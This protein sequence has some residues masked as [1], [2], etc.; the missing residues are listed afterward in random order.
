[1]ILFPTAYLELGCVNLLL[2]H[3]NLGFH[4]TALQ[5]KSFYGRLKSFFVCTGLI[6][7]CLIIGDFLIKRLNLLVGFVNLGLEIA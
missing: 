7:L 4:F 6:K 1:L 3:G 2:D 5:I